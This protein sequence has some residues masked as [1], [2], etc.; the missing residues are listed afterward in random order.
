L[1]TIKPYQREDFLRKLC[2]AR[3]ASAHKIA[4]FIAAAAA[5]APW[6]FGLAALM[7]SLARRGLLK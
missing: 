4:R 3:R 6:T 2:F 7:Q 1:I 5:W